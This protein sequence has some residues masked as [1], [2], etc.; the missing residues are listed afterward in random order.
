MEE[1]K[2][3][4]GDIIVGLDIGTSKV[5]AIVGEVNNFNQIEIISSIKTKCRGI[6]KG[7]IIDMDSVVALCEKNNVSSLE[8][9]YMKLFGD[10]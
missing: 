2:L 1:K 8:E 6:K 7:K 4:I 9:V 3:A 10:E 5:S